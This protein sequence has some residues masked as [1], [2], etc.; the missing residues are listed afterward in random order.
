M[1]ADYTRHDQALG[2][3]QGLGPDLTNG[4]TS[5]VPMVAEALAAMG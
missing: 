5:H 2:L 1:L 4:M 3:L